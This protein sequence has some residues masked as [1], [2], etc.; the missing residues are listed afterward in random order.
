[1]S[2][3]NN[4]NSLSSFKSEKNQIHVYNDTYTHIHIYIYQGV[5]THM[6]NIDKKHFLNIKLDPLHISNFNS[7]KTFEQLIN[8]FTQY[9]VEI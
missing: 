8:L 1:M 9:Q 3:S 5:I 4:S 2:E 7:F 6:Y